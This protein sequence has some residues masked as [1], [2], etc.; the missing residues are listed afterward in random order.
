METDLPPPHSLQ[1]LLG[2]G[3][4]PDSLRQV[5]RWTNTDDATLA[6]TASDY[7]AED[8]RLQEMLEKGR[9]ELWWQGIISAAKSELLRRMDGEGETDGVKGGGK[10]AGGQVNGTGMNGHGAGDGEAADQYQSGKMQI[11]GQGDVVME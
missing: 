7:A 4:S 6:A 11:D 3:T 10:G 5:S 2:A 8:A 1:S 9:V